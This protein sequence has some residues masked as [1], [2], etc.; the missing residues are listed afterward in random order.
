ML[1]SFGCFTVVLGVGVKG[2]MEPSFLQL[3][4]VCGGLVLGVLPAG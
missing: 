1:A 4:R 2:W 3:A